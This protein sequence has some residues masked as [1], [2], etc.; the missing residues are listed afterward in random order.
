MPG[1]AFQYI[2]IP[3]GS[4]LF[5]KGAAPTVIRFV[6]DRKEDVTN[7]ILADDN[8]LLLAD[9]STYIKYE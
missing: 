1:Y 9:N 6:V 7:A 5:G 4:A 3:A 2:N 8:I